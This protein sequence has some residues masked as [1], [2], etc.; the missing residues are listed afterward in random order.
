MALFGG[1]FDPFHL[2]HFLVAR[3]AREKF[4]LRKII[5]IPCAHSPLKKNCPVAGERARLGMLRCGLRDQPWAEVWDGEIHQ[6]GISYTIDTVRVWQRKLSEARL[7][8]IMGSDQWEVLTSW[9]EPK[10]LAQRLHF[11]VFPRPTKPRP[12][13]G[14]RMSEIPLR[15]DISATEVRN[16]IQRGLSVE[17]LMLPCVERLIRRNGW[18]R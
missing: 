2:G 11:F 13:K 12:R 15:I 1:S 9:K 16:R 7:G 17:G 5:F 8:W 3:W 4:R 18:Y 6:G 14:F 10:E